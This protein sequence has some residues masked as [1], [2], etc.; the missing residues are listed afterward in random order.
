[1]CVCPPYISMLIGMLLYIS[2]FV[3]GVAIIR[4]L[5]V[6]SFTCSSAQ[7]HDRI[8]TA[9]SKELHAQT[10]IPGTQ[11]R[12]PWVS[13]CSIPIHNNLAW[14]HIKFHYAIQEYLTPVCRPKYADCQRND[15]DTLTQKFGHVQ[16]TL[17]INCP[18]HSYIQVCQNMFVKEGNIQ[19][20]AVLAMAGILIAV[21]E[22]HDA[23]KTKPPSYR[24]ATSLCDHNSL[25]V[26]R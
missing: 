21:T 3:P 16:H 17:L 23:D 9:S 6:F 24:A 19:S 15:I 5:G 26:Q 7:G 12:C 14:T 20:K 2:L 13:Y 25:K 22:H 4:R 18:L 10:T 1:M 11:Y 8:H